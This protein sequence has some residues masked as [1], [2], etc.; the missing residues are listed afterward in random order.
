[1]FKGIDLFSDTATKPS[2]AMKEAMMSAPLG[3]EQLSEDPTTK[4]LEEKMAAMLNK[5]AAMFFP[6]ATLANQIAVK[7]HTEPGDEV[8]AHEYCHIFNSEGSGAAIHSHVQARMIQSANGIFG[9]EEIVKRFREH[10]SPYSPRSRLVI[11]ENTSNA[12][13]GAVWSQK[14]VQDVLKQTK[15]LNLKSHLDGARLFNAQASLGCKLHELSEGFDTI[16]IC[17][18]KGLGC[19]AGAVLAFDKALYSRLR[20]LKQVFG[21]A[22]RQSGILAAGAH[23]ALENNVSDLIEDHK[24]A[25]LL[26]ENLQKQAKLMLLTPKPQSNMVF[27]SVDRAQ[28]DPDK[29]YSELLKMGLRFSRV[30]KNRFRAVAHRDISFSQIKEACE[31][32]NKLCLR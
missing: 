24:K 31:I 14:E 7:L 4:A 20:R 32:I 17:F 13:G 23:F 16:T 5:E 18:S 25:L 22:L 30:A 2:Q 11:V 8:I 19:P 29:F 15:E 26:A 27:F 28:I 3:D 9:P 1:M 12:G 6:S 21:G 10:S